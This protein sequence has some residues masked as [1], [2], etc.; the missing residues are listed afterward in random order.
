M[1]TE[2]INEIFGEEG[3]TSMKDL[4]GH[5]GSEGNERKRETAWEGINKDYPPISQVGQFHSV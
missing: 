3:G 1:V 2:L 5:F 4:S